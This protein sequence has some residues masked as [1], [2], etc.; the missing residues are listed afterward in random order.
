MKN[1]KALIKKLEANVID[2]EVIEMDLADMYAQDANDATVAYN[3]IVES[4]G[5]NIPTAAMFISNL[6]TSIR[7][8]IVLAIAADKGNDWVL[9]NLGFEVYA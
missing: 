6:D 5:A 7:E 2:P 4:N 8:G 3:F 9:S 1:L